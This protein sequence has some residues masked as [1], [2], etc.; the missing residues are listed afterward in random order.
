MSGM[1]IVLEFWTQ[2]SHV[3]R[4]MNFIEFDLETTKRNWKVSVQSYKVALVYG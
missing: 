4:C 1:V 3:G 2:N